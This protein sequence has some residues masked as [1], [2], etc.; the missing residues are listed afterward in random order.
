MYMYVNELYKFM[1][2]LVLNY[3]YSSVRFYRMV[4]Q[5]TIAWDFVVTQQ[6]HLTL[7]YM[8]EADRV[9]YQLDTTYHYVNSSTF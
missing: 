5:P 3:Q 8:C 1:D 6:R 9:V 4:S 7:A 2:L